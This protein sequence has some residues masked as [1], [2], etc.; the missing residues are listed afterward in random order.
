MI[1]IKSAAILAF[2]AS[3]ALVAAC[4]GG[5]K[6]V[7]NSNSSS[8]SNQASDNANS[9]KTNVEELGVL[10]HIPFETEDIVWKDD[11]MSKNLVAVMR[12]SPAD[13]AAIVADAE[14][15]APPK[16]VNLASESWFPAELIAQSD[17]SGDDTL[18]GKSYA[19]NAFFQE[20]YTSGTISR[21]E[22]T[23][24]F[25]LEVSMK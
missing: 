23:E 10:V 14:K 7:V 2:I 8:V 24:Y 11:Q 18:N 20:P 12:F 13:S 19:A 3:V 16:S 21:I 9:A 22:G 25:I 17:M 5:V 4:V 15:I 6:T 1:G